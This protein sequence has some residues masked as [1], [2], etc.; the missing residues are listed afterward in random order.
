MAI[1]GEQRA[2]ICRVGFRHGKHPCFDQRIPALDESDVGPKDSEVRRGRFPSRECLAILVQPL[3]RLAMAEAVFTADREPG[4]QVV[5]GIDGE[6][7][8]AL[9][10]Q[11]RRR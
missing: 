5:I 10:G 8:A 1:Q 11:I 4:R 7:M 3:P 6:D 9:G 2:I